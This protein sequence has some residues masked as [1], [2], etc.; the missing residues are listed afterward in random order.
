MEPLDASINNP[1]NQEEDSAF[2]LDSV[3]TALRRFWFFVLLAAAAGGA[4]AYYIAGSQRYVYQKTASVM[5]RD[6]KSQGDSSSE[7]ILSELGADQGAAN[8]SNESLILKTTALMQQV[9]EGKELQT[10]YW[11]KRGFREEEIYQDTPI[12]VV[13]EKIND[14]RSCR[15]EVT[16]VSDTEL[17][18]S[19]PNGQGEPVVVTGQF[20]QTIELPFATLTVHPST[21]MN[22]AWIGTPIIVNRQSTISTTRTLLANL[23]ITRS[24]ERDASVLVL[25]LTANNPAKAEDILNALIEAYNIQ[26]R[27]A[28]SESARKT[29]QFIRERLAAI[30]AELSDVDQKMADKRAADQIVQGADAT[31]SADFSASQAVEQQLF[32]LETKIELGEKLAKDFRTAATMNG[33]IAVDT[34]IADTSIS[35]NIEAYNEA[36]LQYTSLTKSAGSRNPTVIALKEKMQ[37]TLKAGNRSLAA[38]QK[39]LELQKQALEDKKRQLTQ[40]LSATATHAQELTPLMREHKVKEELYLMLLTKEQENALSLAIAEPSAR[41]LEAAYGSDAPISPNTR[42]F[43]IGGTVGGGALCLFAIIGIGML[44]NKVNTKHDLAGITK[45]PVIG[46]LPQLTRKE[47]NIPDLFIRDT[48]AIAT[49]CFH[50][51]RHNADTLIP[52]DPAGGSIYMLTSTMAGEGKTTCIANLALAFAKTGRRI[53][54]VDADLRKFSLSRRLGGKG[55]KGLSTLLLNQEDDPMAIIHHLPDTPLQ[56]IDILYAGPAV[57]NPVTLLSQASFSELIEGLRHCYDIVLIDTPP[58]PILADASII[59]DSADACL[60]IIRAGQIDKRYIAQVCHTAAN[61]NLPN[62]A[63][64]LNGVDFKASSYSYYGYGYGY[65]YGIKEQKQALAEQQQ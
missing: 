1:G 23:T 47:R 6:S 8:L 63:F 51:L 39:N 9:V 45:Q 13:F 41:V 52:R 65:G 49:E 55:R 34:G 19:Y 32:E 7:R 3:L 10:S 12:R 36:Y 31:L 4:I 60:Y 27:A 29:E 37:E 18:I 50:I 15:L 5:M 38:Y 2:S 40:R 24:E 58:L 43:L 14:N 21:H 25:K 53:L 61:R 42:M 11:V 48:H 46:E 64:I 44:N 30:G 17:S 20:G 56:G 28:R 54:L 62:L 33:L 16:P 26:S 59:A 35:G 22:Q 57:A